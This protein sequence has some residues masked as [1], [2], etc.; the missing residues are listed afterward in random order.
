MPSPTKAPQL[1]FDFPTAMKAIIDGK[2]VTKLEWNDVT[3]YCE[4]H[5]QWLMI[6]RD[7]QWFTWTVSDGDMLGQDWVV[8]E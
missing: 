2:R 1:T 5:G 3:M 6:H 7:G 4:L 8:L